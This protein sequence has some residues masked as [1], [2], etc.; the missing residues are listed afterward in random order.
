MKYDSPSKIK[1]LVRELDDQIDALKDAG[2]TPAYIVLS[3]DGYTAL[4][5]WASHA[6][7]YDHLEA[8]RRWRDCRLVA[9]AA[10]NV[11]EVVPEADDAWESGE[12][13]L[14]AKGLAPMP[15]RPFPHDDGPDE[16]ATPSPTADDGLF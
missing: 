10:E 14:A 9:V 5:T 16:A 15:A 4:I 8:R 7:G 11:A 2:L 1:S 13:F 3:L 6:D 12:A